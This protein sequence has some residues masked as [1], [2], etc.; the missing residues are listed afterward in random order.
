M[1]GKRPRVP[2][3][4][5]TTSMSQLGSGSCN[6]VSEHAPKEKQRATF[7]AASKSRAPGSGHTSL[8]SWKLNPSDS[9]QKCS[10]GAGLSNPIQI[11]A[12]GALSEDM[13]FPE[14]LYST[15]PLFMGS[16]GQAQFHYHSGNSDIQ[17]Q[18]PITDSIGAAG[19]LRGDHFLSII[20]AA[21]SGVGSSGSVYDVRVVEPARF[22]QACFL[23]TRRLGHGQDI[24]MYRYCSIFSAIN[25]V[26]SIIDQCNVYLPKQ[27]M[28]FGNFKIK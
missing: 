26:F 17:R 20:D 7:S 6:P 5:R 27:A 1:L 21:P 10:N 2:S 14:T 12:L 19:E 23:C 3:M 9:V 25:I 18:K 4:R 11:S 8:P 22:L 13:G 15:K 28:R 24:Y 16:Q